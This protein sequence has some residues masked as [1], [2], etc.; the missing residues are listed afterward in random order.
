MERTVN[1][2][3]PPPHGAW[4]EGLASY[5][6]VFASFHVGNSLAMRTARSKL[7]TLIS[8]TFTP[9]DTGWRDPVFASRILV[10]ILRATSRDARPTSRPRWARRASSVSGV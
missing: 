5:D 8:S 7:W 3:R 1:R 10:Q 4:R 9:K 2:G 6:G